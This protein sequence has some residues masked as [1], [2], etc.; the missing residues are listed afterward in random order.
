MKPG[1]DAAAALVNARVLT[2]G[3]MPLRPEADNSSDWTTT[4]DDAPVRSAL[5][6]MLRL[7]LVELWFDATAA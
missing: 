2:F 7:V 4:P 6:V 5:L 3:L 1:C